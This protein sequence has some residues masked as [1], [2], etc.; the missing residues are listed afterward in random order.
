M[1][2]R[3]RVCVCVRGVYMYVCVKFHLTPKT[4]I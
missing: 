4:A 3:A 2:V 1:C